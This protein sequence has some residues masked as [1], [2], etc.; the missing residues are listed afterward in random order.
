MSRR[1]PCILLGAHQHIG[2][3]CQWAHCA[4]EGVPL[5]D[6]GVWLGASGYEI[7]SSLARFNTLLTVFFETPQLSAVSC[8]L[9][10]MADSRRIKRYLVISVTSLYCIYAERRIT[11]SIRQTIYGFLTPECRFPRHGISGFLYPGIAVS[12]RRTG[13]VMKPGLFIYPEAQSIHQLASLSE[14]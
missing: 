11:N 8:W 1:M 13:G 4:P 3:I 5:T 2:E 6:F 10:P 9:N 14:T 7:V 12:K